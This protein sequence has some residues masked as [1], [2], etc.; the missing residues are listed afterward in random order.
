MDAGATAQEGHALAEGAAATAGKDAAASA[1]RTQPPLD[2]TAAT[3]AAAAAAND[4]D[5]ESGPAFTAAHPSVRGDACAPPPASYAPPWDAR[6]PRA[7][8]RS[9]LASCAAVVAALAVLLPL[10]AAHPRVALALLA[11]AA[12]ANAALQARAHAHHT[13]SFAHRITA[14]S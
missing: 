3:A 12:L 6:A 11:A 13:H 10:A 14:R 8:R 2:A 4:A 5:D 1:H 7:R 9:R